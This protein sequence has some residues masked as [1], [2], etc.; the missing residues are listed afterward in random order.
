MSAIMTRPRWST[1][2]AQGAHRT[3][4]GVKSRTP[5]RC[6]TMSGLDLILSVPRPESVA[7]PLNSVMKR[8]SAVKTWTR[9]FSQSAM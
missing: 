4:S 9:L 8:P 6:R 2:T 5:L 1:R 7:S 3:F